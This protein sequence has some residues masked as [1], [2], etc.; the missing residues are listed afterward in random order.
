MLGHGLAG[1]VQLGGGGAGVVVGFALVAFSGLLRPIGRRAR[2]GPPGRAREKDAATPTATPTIRL[3]EIELGLLAELSLEQARAHEELIGDP[4]LRPETRRRAAVSALAWRDRARAFQLHARGK[5]AAPIVS[6]DHATIISS[7]RAT[8]VRG[9]YSSHVY[10]GP[11]RRRQMRRRESR[12]GDAQGSGG[13]ERADRRSGHER[14][15]GDRR[16]P[17]LAPR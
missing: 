4:S 13:V 10:T 17:E 6:S 9:D 15:Q 3:N 7:D 11:E 1:A 14:R 2:V 5:G 8:I 12:R 16:G